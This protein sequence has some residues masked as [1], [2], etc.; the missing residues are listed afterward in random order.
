M[1]EGE[2]GKEGDRWREGGREGE[3]GRGSGGSTT[4]SLEPR[5]QAPSSRG[6]Q[7]LNNNKIL[8]HNH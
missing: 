8:G 6:P 7:I 5:P 4:G 1:S 3:R 2:G